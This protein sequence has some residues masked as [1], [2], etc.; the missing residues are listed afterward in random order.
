VPFVRLRTRIKE[1]GP[2][3]RISLKTAAIPGGFWDIGGVC[4]TQGRTE[5]ALPRLML[6]DAG[7]KGILLATDEIGSGLRA[8]KEIADLQAELQ[9][10]LPQNSRRARKDA[11]LPPVASQAE[12]SASSDAT[13]SR[14]RAIS[15][16]RV[17]LIDCGPLVSEPNLKSR[18][19]I[20]EI[21]T[22]RE[23][24]PPGRT[25]C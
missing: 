5:K 3:G 23:A 24:L 18:E 21:L 10:P 25:N 4:R 2:V 22:N 8:R 14:P 9:R 20:D 19:I 15:Q 7:T 13:S 11:G 17:D 12:G 16:P 1:L 6:L